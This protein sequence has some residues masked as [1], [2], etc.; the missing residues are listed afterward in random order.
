MEKICVHCSAPAV[1]ISI[2]DECFCP[3]CIVDF[4]GQILVDAKLYD[5]YI[6]FKSEEMFLE[7]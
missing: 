7:K 2:L 5:Q 3:D 1:Y 6:L 4:I